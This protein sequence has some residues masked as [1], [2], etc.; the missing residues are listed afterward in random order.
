MKALRNAPN[1]ILF[2]PTLVVRTIRELSDDD[3]THMAAGVAYYALFSL[4][5]FLLG[6]IAIIGLAADSNT[7]RSE[8]REWAADNLPGTGDFIS[9]NVIAS[10]EASGS[11]GAISIIGLIWSGSAIFGAI[12]KVVNRAW[13]IQHDRPF[14]KGK[15]MQLSMAMSVG[16]LFALALTTAS[17]AQTAER[18]AHTDIPVLAQADEV[19]GMLLLRI[20]SFVF[21]LAIFLMLY[22]VL[23]NTRTHWRYIWPGALVAALLFEGGKFLFVLYLDNFATFSAVYGSIGSVIALLLWAYVSAFILILGAEMSS[24]FGRMIRGI[25]RGKPIVKRSSQGPFF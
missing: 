11:L 12:T 25:D 24:E 22:K 17:L 23:P 16:I 6:L 7:V 9:D 10:A 15:I 2:V 13:D 20:L 19:L 18:Y 21:N 14:I 5:P 4:F 1:L 8:I 3:A